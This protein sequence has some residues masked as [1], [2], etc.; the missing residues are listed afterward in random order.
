MGGMGGPWRWARVWPWVWPGLGVIL[1]LCSSGAL[2]R[3]QGSAV[4]PSGGLPK[5]DNASPS[6]P[7]AA[8]TTGTHRFW[9]KTNLELFAGVTAVRALDFTSTQHFRERGHNE[10]L[11]SNSVVDNKPLYASIEGAG[12][13]A[14][15]GLAYYLHRT[16]HHRLERWT[17]IVH[18]GVASAGDVHNYLLRR[19]KN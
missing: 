7:R 19:G 15:I 12:V 8:F 3:A 18:I 14:S 2:A 13:A 9:D 17:S 6:T 16:G 1:S 4:T 5:L 11:L 10:V